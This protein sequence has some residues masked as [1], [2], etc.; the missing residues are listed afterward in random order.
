M[1]WDEMELC[2]KAH[3]I[4][5]REMLDPCASAYSA[6]LLH[7]ALTSSGA[8]CHGGGPWV[9]SS[10]HHHLIKL[11][12]LGCSSRLACHTRTARH[13]WLGFSGGS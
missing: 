7:A 4:A 2:C 5:S 1:R 9:L 10:S 6:A 12:M 13:E 3:L 11:I 8:G